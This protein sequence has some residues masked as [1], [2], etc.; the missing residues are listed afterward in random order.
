MTDVPGAIA[1]IIALLVRERDREPDLAWHQTA[2]RETLH[3]GE[4]GGG[5][6]ARGFRTACSEERTGSHDTGPECG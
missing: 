5:A 2:V 1:I 6:V 4:V 3:H